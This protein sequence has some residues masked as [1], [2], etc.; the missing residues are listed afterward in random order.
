MAASVALCG[1]SRDKTECTA[2]Y[3]GYVDLDELSVALRQHKHSPQQT[4]TWVLVSGMTT[5]PLSRHDV[6]ILIIL[7]LLVEC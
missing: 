6:C 7:Q 5:A 3:F 1:V 2:S 4:W